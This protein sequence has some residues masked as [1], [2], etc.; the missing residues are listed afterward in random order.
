MCLGGGGSVTA[1]GG[2]SYD[3]S[4]G[5]FQYS[6]PDLSS[7]VESSDV[8]NG[9]I[10]ISAGNALST[11]GSFTT[12]QSGNATITINHSDTSTLSGGYGGNDNGI[13]IE[14]ITV[15]GRGHVTAIGTRDLDSRFVPNNANIV[16]VNSAGASG[17]GNLEYDSGTQQFTFT[18]AATSGCGDI[19]AV[20]AG[21][22]LS[23]GGTSGAVSLALD[24]GELTEKTD[25]VAA[26]SDFLVVFDASAGPGIEERKMH[27]SNIDVSAF[28]ND[29]NYSTGGG[30][31][32]VSSVTN[33]ANNRVA[34][35]SGA[36]SLN[37]EANLTFA[38][39]YTHL[40]LPTKA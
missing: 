33:G 23:G 15:D 7:F 13:V 18:P 39:S 11:G 35:F 24:V 30:S 10:T 19:T 34:T 40:T 16:V 3:N 12:N 6:P 17:G 36:D 27:F 2:I 9:T 29:A 1:T 4:N 32:A 38:V 5:V 21:N 22:G 25:A 20:T 37:G 28:N 26:S 31:G 14:D 8:R